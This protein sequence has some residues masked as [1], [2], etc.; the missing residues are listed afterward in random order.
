MNKE[1]AKKILYASI[2]RLSSRNSGL[3]MSMLEAEVINQACYA[4]LLKQREKTQVAKTAEELL[5]GILNTRSF[6]SGY[7]KAFVDA[8]TE[9]FAEYGPAEAIPALN[10]IDINIGWEGMWDHL[11]EYFQKNHGISIDNTDIEGLT[12]YSNRHQRFENENFVSE[13]EVER[14]VKV[15]LIDGGEE[16]MVEIVPSLTPKKGHKISSQGSRR[17]F[18][19]Y[20]TDYRFSFELDQFDEIKNFRL[21]ILPRKIRIDYFE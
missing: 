18:N 1:E 3:T 7:A 21:E 16:I 13:S 19:G 9:M 15:T 11:R 14:I 17:V 2:N 8:A 5:A 12:F 4:I 6:A 20:D 10:G